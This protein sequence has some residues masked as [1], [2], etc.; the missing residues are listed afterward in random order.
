M[1][2]R[3]ICLLYTSSSC[4]NAFQNG[5]IGLMPVVFDALLVELIFDLMID[6]IGSVQELLLGTHLRPL[7][8]V[9]YTHL[10]VYKRQTISFLLYGCI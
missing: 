4:Q 2:H 3:Y 10:D 5:D 8:P 7:E 1:Y 6:D 9:S